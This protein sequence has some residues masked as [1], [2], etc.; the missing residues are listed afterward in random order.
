MK[1]KY[2]VPTWAALGFRDLLDATFSLY[3]KHFR[4]FF[5]IAVVYY[6]FAVGMDMLI[7]FFVEDLNV[8]RTHFIVKAYNLLDHFLRCFVFTGFIAASLQT[9]LGRQMTGRAALRHVLHRFLPCFY[10]WL[11][12]LFANSVLTRFTSGLTALIIFSNLNRDFNNL[13]SDSWTDPTRLIAWI[14]ATLPLSLFAF[15]FLIRWLFYGMSVLF[16][17]TTARTALRR[18]TELVKGSWWRI[19]GITTAIYLLAGMIEVILF[20]VCVSPV[21]LTGL[22]EQAF[23]LEMI[24]RLLSSSPSQVGWLVY[25]ILQFMLRSVH[26]LA[27]LPLLAIGFTLLYFDMRIRKEGFDLQMRIQHQENI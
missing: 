26:A 3:R 2:H 15:Y 11:F 24:S 8:P 10:G 9:Y 1:H 23:S 19:F 4:V 12:L 27:S 25:V 18:S 6:V 17:G 21:L 5:P 16:E 14:V 20:G 22:I 13:V 7:V